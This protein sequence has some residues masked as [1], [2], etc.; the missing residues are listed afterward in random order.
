MRPST[1]A[2]INNGIERTAR[3]LRVSGNV[4]FKH[5]NDEQSGHINTA[6]LTATD[7]VLTNKLHAT[8]NSILSDVWAD[9]IASRQIR[10]RKREGADRQ[11]VRQQ[12]QIKRYL[13][14]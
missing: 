10:T 2:K 13:E 12:A 9:S 3:A 6:T 5:D 4:N 8:G 7:S 11:L 14:R 1:S